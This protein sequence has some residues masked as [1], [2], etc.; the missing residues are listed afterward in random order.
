MPID[1]GT[2]AATTVGTTGFAVLGLAG[3]LAP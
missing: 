3:P 1:R 2:G